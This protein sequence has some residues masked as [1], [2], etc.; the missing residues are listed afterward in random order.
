MKKQIFFRNGLNVQSVICQYYIIDLQG[1]DLF[2]NIFHIS[3]FSC[4]WLSD[5]LKC[6][7]RKYVK[8]K[9]NRVFLS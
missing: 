5:A 3:C 1:R 2:L 7:D 6:K 4:T 9:L 8:V